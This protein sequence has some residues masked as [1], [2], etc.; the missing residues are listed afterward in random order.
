VRSADHLP[1]FT[2]NIAMKTI[3][4]LA[5]EYHDNVYNN[6]YFTAEVTIDKGLPEETIIP[7]PYQYGYDDH[8]IDVSKN[9]LHKEGHLPGL[10][11]Y[12]HGMTEPL[13]RYC[14]RNNIILRTLKTTGHK[15]SEL[16][17]DDE[18]EEIKPKKRYTWQ[19]MNGVWV[20]YDKHNSKIADGWGE[21]GKSRKSKS[22]V[23]K[24]IVQMNK[25]HKEQG[26]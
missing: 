6:S 19:E 22:L 24:D 8:Y 9:K 4:I 25:I 11:E 2:K 23:Q 12:N 7:I 1:R 5:K 21:G 3:D 16:I 13:W 15:R 17:L 18:E 10:E 26:D 14:E 20:V